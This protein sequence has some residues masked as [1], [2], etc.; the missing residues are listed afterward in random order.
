MRLPC[1]PAAR[2]SRLGA[3]LALLAGVLVCA[4]CGRGARS[5][6]DLLVH[7]GDLPRPAGP[8]A[9]GPSPMLPGGEATSQAP[10]EG[11]AGL[12]ASRIGR[13]RLARGGSARLA[14]PPWRVP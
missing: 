3:A 13:L 4:G 11:A 10:Y 6:P 1:L 8:A 5:G 7:V 14:T 2:S 9:G 12:S